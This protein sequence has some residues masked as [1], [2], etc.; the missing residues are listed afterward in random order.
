MTIFRFRAAA[1][2]VILSGCQSGVTNLPKVNTELGRIAR[3]SN[4]ADRAA[5]LKSFAEDRLRNRA[6][7]RSDFLHAGFRETQFREKGTMCQSFNWTSV[8]E[9]FPI[10]MLVN[11]CGDDVFANAGQ[12]AP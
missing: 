7:L 11:I 12:I 8:G 10:V 3:I 1:F 5:E 9:I 4:F 6:Q 2:A